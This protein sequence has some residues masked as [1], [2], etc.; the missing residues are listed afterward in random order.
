MNAT[1]ETSGQQIRQIRETVSPKLALAK[2]RL[3]KRKSEAA[4]AP[5]LHPPT[6][7]LLKEQPPKKQTNNNNNKTKR[8]NNNSK[9]TNKQT[10]KKRCRERETATDR[11]KQALQNHSL[12]KRK[13]AR[14]HPKTRTQVNRKSGLALFAKSFLHKA[15]LGKSGLNVR[16]AKNGH[17]KPPTQDI[18]TFICPDHKLEFSEND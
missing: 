14:S 10:N 7:T 13:S 18:R 1:T 17:L 2:Y 8:N 9:Q 5:S 16:V 12:A 15:D 3:R 11:K 6:K 4:T